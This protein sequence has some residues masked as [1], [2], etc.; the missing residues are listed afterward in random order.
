MYIHTEHVDPLGR[1]DVWS[2]G[3]SLLA[4]VNGAQ[5]LSDLTSRL[6]MEIE[7]CDIWNQGVYG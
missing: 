4:L 3:M 7:L 1:G 6:Q 2:L 5:P